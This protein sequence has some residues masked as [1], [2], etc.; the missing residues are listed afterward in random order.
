MPPQDDVD[1]GI[2][3]INDTNDSSDDMQ[4]D[5]LDV[6]D[7]LVGDMPHMEGNSSIVIDGMALLQSLDKTK[8]IKICKD[9]ASSFITVAEKEFEGHSEC[10]IIF[11]RYDLENSLKKPER[12]R[13]QQGRPIISYNITDST[14]IDK[15]SLKQLLSSTHTK[16]RLTS[17]LGR[18]L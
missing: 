8:N 14:K 13:R 2:P 16:D 11:D 6:M 17:F 4:S 7:D 9:L 1:G 12:I 10:H 15:I 18:K 5:V 3:F